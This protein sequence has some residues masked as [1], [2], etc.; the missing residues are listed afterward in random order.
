MKCRSIFVE[1]QLPVKKFEVTV[2]FNSNGKYERM[3]LCIENFIGDTPNELADS[4]QVWVD[5]L[6]KIKIN[7][8]DDA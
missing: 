2:E 8:E 5:G 6:R 3:T 1:N 7:G 4:F